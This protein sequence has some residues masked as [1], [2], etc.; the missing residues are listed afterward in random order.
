MLYQKQATSDFFY[1]AAKILF[2]PVANVD[3]QNVSYADYLRRTRS[4]IFYKERQEKVDFGTSDGQREL[5]YLKRDEINKAERAAY[6]IKIA[7]AKNITISDQEIDAELDKNLKTNG[8]EAMAKIDYENN[9]LKQ[10]FG[11]TMSD[12]RAELHNRLLERKVAFAVDDTAKAKI[13]KVEAR[14][15][16]GEDFAVVANE[17]SDDEATRSTGGGV[18]A[19]TGDADPNELITAARNLDSG[20]ISGIIQGIDGYYIVKLDA[21]TDDS[22]RY[23]MIKVSLTK[24]SS[25]FDKLRKDGKI[26]EYIKIPALSDIERS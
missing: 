4:A 6:A 24:F 21:K 26:K 9:V 13:A 16:A 18:S 2:L 7:R 23:L 22:T 5:D 11:W 8:G 10:Y 19:Q 17:M 25:D 12:Y 20:A 15:K 1:N 3:G 14:L